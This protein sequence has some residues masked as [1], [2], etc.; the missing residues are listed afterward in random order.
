MNPLSLVSWLVL[1]GISSLS[2]LSERVFTIAETA[3]SLFDSLL[4]ISS[5]V[6]RASGAAP[7]TSFI[8]SLTSLEVT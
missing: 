2:A 7:M 3:S 6:L 8:F 4:A 5:K 1:V